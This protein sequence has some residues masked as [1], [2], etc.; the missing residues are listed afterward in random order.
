MKPKESDPAEPMKK[1][2][3]ATLEAIRKADKGWL[4][5]VQGRD[6]EK[7]VSHYHEDA[8]WLLRGEPTLIGID[9]I[10]GR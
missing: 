6:P 5:A 10:L 1:E 8:T 4:R 3:D 9:A 7:L 2:T